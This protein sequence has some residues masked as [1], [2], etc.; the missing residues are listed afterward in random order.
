[1][2][3]RD[4]LEVTRRSSLQDVY[5]PTGAVI[6]L[7]YQTDALALDVY[8]V[9]CEGMVGGGG[10]L[11][12]QSAR[13]NL[14][15]QIGGEV[16]SM[17]I[18]AFEKHSREDPALRELI[19]L[20]QQR[21]VSGI[22]QSVVCNA[23]HSIADRTARALLLSYVRAGRTRFEMTHESLARMLG[24]G[25]SG[26]SLAIEELQAGGLIRSRMGQITILDLEALSRVS[27][28]CYGQ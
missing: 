21:T 28:D 17:P 2:H 20:Y 3:S 13:Y 14:V 4:E 11:E 6:S 16:L 5:F 18:A 8:G 27:C 9:G 12:P 25:R 15:C 22:L 24:V 26:V 19:R 7:L 1:M 23:H 10:V